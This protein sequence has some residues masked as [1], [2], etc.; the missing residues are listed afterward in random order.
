MRVVSKLDESV[1]EWT[2]LER[3]KGRRNRRMAEAAGVPVRWVQRLWARYK[4]LPNVAHPLPMGRP[5]NGL[6]GRRGHSSVLTAKDDRRQDAP[7][8][9]RRV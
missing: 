6:P 7:S 3:R 1:A 8:C 9:T 5:V 2:I 4:D